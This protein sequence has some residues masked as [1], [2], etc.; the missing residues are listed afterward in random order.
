MNVP[1]KGVKR[2]E[3]VANTSGKPQICV[4]IHNSFR[5]EI[6]PKV[7][8]LIEEAGISLSRDQRNP[9]F[10]D[11]SMD[12]FERI[13]TA[14]KDAPA[15]RLADSAERVVGKKLFDLTYSPD[16]IVG[17]Y[18]Y[19]IENK[20]Q[21]LLNMARTLLESDA[22]DAVISVNRKT[23]T[24]NYREHL[25]PCI[26]LHNE[27][28]KMAVDKKHPK[29]MAEI[30]RENLKIANI[31]PVE[32]RK[33]DIELGLRTKMPRGWHFGDDVYARLSAA[34]VEIAGAFDDDAL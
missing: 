17:R 26:C 1:K 10:G 3:V 27:L 19:A 6:W 14:L 12:V 31:L 18:V 9:H 25:V 24:N 4:A 30:V 33:I 15:E 7:V 20:D 28:I 21:A 8:E 23:T 16:L 2:L 34:G 5:L 29:E 11:F 32:A 22:H 13:Y